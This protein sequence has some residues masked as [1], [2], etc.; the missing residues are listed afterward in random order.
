M[1]QLRVSA[2]TDHLKQ[3]K[4]HGTAFRR[5]K[6]R[7]FCHVYI[8]FRS[9]Q[10]VL[11]SFWSIWRSQRLKSKTIIPFFHVFEVT[12]HIPQAPPARRAQQRSTLPTCPIA[13]LNG[14]GR[15]GL[16]CCRSPLS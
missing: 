13:P 11:R 1:C 12:V 7:E 2:P 5:E 9:N 16:L 8:S 6:Y 10:T 4:K 3:K 15:I 14:K